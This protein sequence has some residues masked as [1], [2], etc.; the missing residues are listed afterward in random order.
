M[1]DWRVWT[2]VAAL[3][4]VFALD[5][6]LPKIVLLPFMYVPAVAVAT[7]AGSRPTGVL[8]VLALTLGVVSGFINGYIRTDDYWYRL[9]GMSLVAALAVHLAHLSARREWRLVERGGAPAADAGQHR[10]RG[11]PI[12]PGRDA[13]VGLAVVAN[14]VRPGPGP[15]RQD[16]IPA[17]DSPGSGGSTEGVHRCR[18]RRARSLRPQ[19]RCRPR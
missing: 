6:Q 15:G 7:F 8:A 5:I 14:R 9:A 11:A 16:R 10:R 3:G 1:R 19:R 18:P 13:V 17:G 4:A 2:L 12:R